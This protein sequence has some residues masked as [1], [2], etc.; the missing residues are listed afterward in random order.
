M[1]NDG[2]HGGV[3]LAFELLPESLQLLEGEHG[4]NATDNGQTFVVVLLGVGLL[5]EIPGDGAEG[6]DDV[7]LHVGNGE[8]ALQ[9]GLGQVGQSGAI[10][11]KKSP[12]TF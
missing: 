8:G 5:L 11:N 3:V 10:V 6:I 12:K 7:L 1:K 2:L 4:Q 9:V